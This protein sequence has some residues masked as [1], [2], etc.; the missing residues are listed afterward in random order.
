[1]SSDPKS[2]PRL[3]RL[4]IGVEDVEVRLVI[5]IILMS[6]AKVDLFDRI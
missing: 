3:I 4:S 6:E 1:M 2:D 5:N